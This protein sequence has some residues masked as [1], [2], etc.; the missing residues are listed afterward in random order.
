[1]LNHIEGLYII[2]DADLTDSLSKMPEDIQAKLV[3]E[4]VHLQK[5]KMKVDCHSFSQTYKNLETLQDF[6][7]EDWFS[8]RNSVVK[9][10]VNAIASPDKNY[11]HRCLALEHLYDLQGVNFVGPCSFMT[12]IRLLAISNSK[13]TVN[14][15]GKVLPGGSYS[16]LKVWT[17]DLTSEAKYFPSGDCMV[18]IDNDQIVQRK[19]KVK[20][21]QKA[22]VSVVTSVCQAEVDSSG[23]LQTRADLAPRYRQLCFLSFR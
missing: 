7:A 17:R 11:F 21:G 19:W 1:M 12:N 6:R 18:A 5:Q 16:T 20:V 23:L 9:A 10:V 14:M 8:R 2:K 22:R 15:I 3:H 4:V 13:L